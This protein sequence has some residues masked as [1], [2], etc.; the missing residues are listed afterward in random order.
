MLIAFVNAFSAHTKESEK[1]LMDTIS[2]MLQEAQLAL[3]VAM[4]IGKDHLAFATE[5]PIGIVP[6]GCLNKKLRTF[7]QNPKNFC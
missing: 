3:V 1:A 2:M 6:R 7:Y 4:A 5:F